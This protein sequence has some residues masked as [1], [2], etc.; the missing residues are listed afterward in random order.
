[1]PG[2]EFDPAP[3]HLRMAL[4]DTTEVAQKDIPKR[5]NPLDKRAD[6]IRRFVP[7]LRPPERFG[8]ALHLT[9]IDAGDVGMDVR[10]ARNLPR[11]FA[12][13][14]IKL[15]SKIRATRQRPRK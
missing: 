8:Q 4:R 6:R 7:L 15:S 3:G 5:R 14:W 10:C 13:I 1:M 11:D 9:A 2:P 12:S